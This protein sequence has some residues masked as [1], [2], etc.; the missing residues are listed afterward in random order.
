[1][2]PLTMI[3]GLI[4]FAGKAFAGDYTIEKITDNSNIDSF[5][6]N[7]NNRGEVTWLNNNNPGG[8]FN[9]L[10]YSNGTTS[11]I[12]QKAYN[13]NP[14]QINDKGSVAW[15]AVNEP[16]ARNIELYKNGAVSDLSKYTGC[17]GMAYDAQLGNN[18]TVTWKQACD[19]AGARMVCYQN[20][21]A[22]AI[23]HQQYP[24]ENGVITRSAMSDDGMKVVWSGSEQHTQHDDGLVQNKGIYLYDTADGTLKT[25]YDQPSVGGT[26][27]VNNKGQAVWY[28][29]VRIFDPVAG[30]YDEYDQIMY[31]DG[32]N[33]VKEIARSAG[34]TNALDPQINNRSEIVWKG[35]DGQICTFDG[36]AVKQ[37]TFDN[38]V[39]SWEPQINDKGQIVWSSPNTYY[40]QIFLY[41]NGRI[42]QLTN[43]ESRNLW[44]MIND[45]GDICWSG[46]DGYSNDIYVAW[47]R[48]DGED[49]CSTDQPVPEPGTWA[50]MIMGT[51]GLLRSTLRH[52]K[53]NSG[54]H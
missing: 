18:D 33:E 13:L 14:P 52:R 10:L 40:E 53:A 1:M 3:V 2:L 51:L 42:T 9:V 49:G 12:G 11:L 26:I 50:M 20:G 15:E 39:L 21:T 29:E 31:Y 4:L 35:L 38:S 25:I 45:R 47:Y 43:T 41:D 37:L 6:C 34:L 22:A 36:A 23:D 16:E 54:S 5:L 27:D 28:N 32:N 48:N 17:T 46:G 24:G 8:D 7:I 19:E 44:P 30:Q